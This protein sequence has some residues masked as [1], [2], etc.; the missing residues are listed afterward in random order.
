MRAVICLWSFEFSH[1]DMATLGWHLS[2][3]KPQYQK[4]PLQSTPKNSL[5]CNSNRLHTTIHSSIQLKHTR[6]Q[7]VKP[8]PSE[9]SLVWWIRPS[10]R[11]FPPPPTVRYI[12]H[13][14]FTDYS[15]KIIDSRRGSKWRSREKNHRRRRRL[16]VGV[17]FT[18]QWVFSESTSD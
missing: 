16:C 6:A 5:N 4:K 12:W 9:R 2:H 1:F 3:S 11:S 10:L 17:L 8:S 7:I 13:W 14:T 18:Q 15:S